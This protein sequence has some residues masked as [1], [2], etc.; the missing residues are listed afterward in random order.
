[1]EFKHSPAPWKYT[2]RNANE[3]MTTFHGVTIGDVYLDIT[4][5][6]QKA[7]SHL[8]AAAPELLEALIELTESAKEA[9]DGLGD[10]SDAID[11]AKAAIAKALGQQ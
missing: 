1:M 6:N 9:I 4:T 2:I 5:A 8:I 7:D 10:L 3:I 11:T